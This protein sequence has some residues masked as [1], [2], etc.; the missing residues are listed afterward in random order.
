M[1]NYLRD[2]TVIVVAIGIYKAIKNL[3]ELIKWAKNLP[4]TIRM[5]KR[6][7]KENPNAK[8]F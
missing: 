1:K 5:I 8:W 7:K 6:M 3:P 2:V 4:K